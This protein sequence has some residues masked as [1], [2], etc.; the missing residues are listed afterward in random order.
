MTEGIKTRQAKEGREKAV[1]W[2]STQTTE[3]QDT[4]VIVRSFVQVRMATIW[5]PL[6]MTGIH[7]M[8]LMN[9]GLVKGGLRFIGVY[10]ISKATFMNLLY[11]MVYGYFSSY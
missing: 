7:R 4:Q 1:R 8:R 5:T 11:F 9:K 2:L 3:T 6:T 10:E